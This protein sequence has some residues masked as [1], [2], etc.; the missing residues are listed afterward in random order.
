MFAFAIKANLVFT[1]AAGTKPSKRKASTPVETLRYTSADIDES[2]RIL[3]VLAE[4]HRLL[5]FLFQFPISF[6]FATRS[7]NG[8]SVRLDG[9]WDHVA[10]VIAALGD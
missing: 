2:H 6:K 4:R 7:K 5:V 1:Q 9:N 8:E 10:D 3:Y